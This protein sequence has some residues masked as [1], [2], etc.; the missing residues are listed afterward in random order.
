VLYYGSEEWD[1]KTDIHGL[2]GLEENDV[3]KQHIPN[4]QV[5]L[6]NVSE[7]ASKNYLKSDLHWIFS[8]IQYKGNKQKMIEYVKDNAEHFQNLEIDSYQAARILLG[9]CNQLKSPEKMK[10][11]TDMCKALDEYY[12]DGVN[13][14]KEAGRIEHLMELVERKLAKGRTP[15]EISDALETSIKEIEEVISLLED[16]SSNSMVS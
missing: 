15:E 13:E 12:Q 9:A 5:N 2:L 7:L 11:E 8:M 14:G 3:I 4:Y 16:N 1:G 6:V 10:G